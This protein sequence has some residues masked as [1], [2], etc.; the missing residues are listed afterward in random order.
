MASN[1]HGIVF[2]VD[3]NHL[4]TVDSS[5]KLNLTERVAVKT[6]EAGRPDLKHLADLLR[7]LQN[8]TA[9]AQS[10]PGQPAAGSRAR[11][12]HGPGTARAGI[13]TGQQTAGREQL[14]GNYPA[15]PRQR[16]WQ[17]VRW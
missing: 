15:Q 16:S 2:E 9:H 14:S 1:E 3:F 11:R 6:G 8:L 7:L 10:P 4:E 13:G 17:A 5:I 12:R